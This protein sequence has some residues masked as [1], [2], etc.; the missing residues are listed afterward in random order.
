MWSWSSCNFIQPLQS[1]LYSLHSISIRKYT[2][3]SCIMFYNMLPPTR[4]VAI[5]QGP[6]VGA[7]AHCARMSWHCTW[8]RI[9]LPLQKLFPRGGNNLLVYSDN[10]NRDDHNLI[11]LKIPA[12]DTCF[13]VMKY[14]IFAAVCEI[15]CQKAVFL[16]RRLS[17]VYQRHVSKIDTTC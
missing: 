13:N 3:E 6:L 14:H 1:M 10:C 17:L 15:A 16:T 5:F 8:S 9:S 4:N 2:N 11:K 12:T 7:A